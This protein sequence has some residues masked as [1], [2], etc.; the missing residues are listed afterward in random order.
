[1]SDIT[2]N[3]FQGIIQTLL[4]TGFAEDHFLRV[5]K[6]CSFL[7]IKDTNLYSVVEEIDKS[8]RTGRRDGAHR[9]Q[10][11]ACGKKKRSDLDY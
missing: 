11:R 6:L 1:M 7:W 5:I 4:I 8:G 3:T 2:V 9:L 10:T